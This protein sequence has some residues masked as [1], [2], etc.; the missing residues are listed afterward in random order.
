M[1]VQNG[2]KMMTKNPRVRLT[3][4]ILAHKL[5]TAFIVAG[6]LM[7]FAPQILHTLFGPGLSESSNKK[8]A[9]LAPALQER[10][11][12]G[13]VKIVDELMHPFAAAEPPIRIVIPSVGIDVPVAE[14][15]VV[16]GYWEVSDV[17]ASHGAGSAF[18]GTLGNTVIFAHAKEGLFLPLRNV[19]KT[20][21][22][23]VFTPNR[24]YQYRVE[25][26]VAVAPTETHMIRQTSD[27]TITLFTCS[28]FLDTKRLVVRAK[29][30][31]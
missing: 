25:S 2:A 12:F 22:I 17:S 10:S 28:G 7:V 21:R 26:I 19:K 24:W 6:I 13:P 3:G 4:L 1:A 23:Y 27:E 16:N 8:T 5:A 31:R 30:D 15:R 9:T 14:A 18:P 11:L 20:D 29:A